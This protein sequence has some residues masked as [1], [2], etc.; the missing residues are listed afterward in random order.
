[1]AFISLDQNMKQP[2]MNLTYPDF[3]NL[4]QNYFTGV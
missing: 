3:V 1:M 4:D 2:A